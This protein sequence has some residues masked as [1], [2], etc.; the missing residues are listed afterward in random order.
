MSTLQPEFILPL[1]LFPALIFAALYDLRYQKIPNLLNFPLALFALIYHTAFTG[2]N[3]LAFGVTG[4]LLGTALFL[5]P[6]IFG[7]MGAGDTK[8]MGAIGAVLG[9]KGVFVS[10]L[11]TAIFGGLYAVL[12]L[13]V[14]RGY[15]RT[16]M[17]RTW[18]GL[19]TLVLVRR[20]IPDSSP[21]ST[22]T[23]PRLCYG[24]AIAL[25][26]LTHVLLQ[27][28]GIDVWNRLFA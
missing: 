3:G 25:G 17:Q 26:T 5:P 23:S 22:N 9:A 15:A 19:K 6:Y 24:I 10:A 14:H 1:L 16:L 20:Y 27:H 8:L 13:L 4:M 18:E 2:L 11:F 21:Q 12:L 7:G 28:L